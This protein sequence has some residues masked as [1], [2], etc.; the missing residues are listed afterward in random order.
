MNGHQQPLF[1][2]S[3]SDEATW[4]V[5]I[6]LLGNVRLLRAGELIPLRAGSKREA[7]LAHL[8]LQYARRVPR[9]QVVQLL[10]PTSEL[11][12]GL[13]SLNNLVYKVQKLLGPALS[14]AAPIVHEEGY[15]RLNVE[16][17][18]G[19]DVACFDSLVDTGDTQ[20]RAGDAAAIPAYRRAVALYRG[21]LALAA[22]G[23]AIVERERL[24][25]RYLTLLMH[26]AAHAYRA[27]DYSVSLEYLWRLLARDPY[28]EDAHRLVMRCFVRRG[29]RAAALHQYQV[30]ADLL[31]AEFDTAP[32]PV[33]VALYEQIRVAPEH[34]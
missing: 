2:G 15:Y 10:W 16:A 7:L 3:C 19:V 20:S 17:G 32:E 33:T 9:E 26:L 31:R 22:D 13:N 27:G 23:Y 1:T 25:A 12:L 11:A 28:R 18:V 8:A 14:G 34:I 24:R 21:D 5:M 29:E 30:C 6:C 4:P